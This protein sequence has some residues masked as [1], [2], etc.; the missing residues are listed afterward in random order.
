[1]FRAMI[2]DSA[3]N[4]DSRLSNILMRLPKSMTL[5]E[6]IRECGLGVYKAMVVHSLI[7]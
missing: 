2:T 4:T 3:R 1:M 5:Y 6:I 7:V